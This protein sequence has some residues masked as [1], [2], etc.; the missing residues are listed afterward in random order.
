MWLEFHFENLQARLCEPRLEL[1]RAQVA[2]LA[3]TIEIDRITG[4]QH[5]PVREQ[6]E[7]RAGLEH[8]AEGFG[9]RLCRARLQ[10]VRKRDLEHELQNREQRAGREMKNRREGPAAVLEADAL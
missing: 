8:E 1:R 3:S 4:S 5:T 6:V 9:E 2:L 7:A 10:R